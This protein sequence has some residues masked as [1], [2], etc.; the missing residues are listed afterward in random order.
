M[1]LK[2]GVLLLRK[3]Q[4]AIML[5]RLCL[6]IYRFPSWTKKELSL[7][8]KEG[9]KKIKKGKDEKKKLGGEGAASPTIRT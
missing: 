2:H 1:L 4:N 8:E 6:G 3:H 5:V 9:G 7:K